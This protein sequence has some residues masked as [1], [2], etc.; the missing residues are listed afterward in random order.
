MVIESHT[1]RVAWAVV[2]GGNIG[3]GKEIV[4]KLLVRG[5]HVIIG[6]R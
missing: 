6:C 2:T 3:L 4:E 1:D 5:F